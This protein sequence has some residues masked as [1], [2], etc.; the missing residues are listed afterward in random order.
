MIDDRWT[1][2]QVDRIQS[3]VL[4]GGNLSPSGHLT[5]S[6]DLFGC[7]NL[8][9]PIGIWWVGARS[10]AKYPTMHSLGPTTESYSTQN[11]NSAEV[12]NPEL[13]LCYSALKIQFGTE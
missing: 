1:D 5:T 6:G 13:D 8:K 11:V 2:K 9:R 10:A 7:C 4:N 3:V 12:K